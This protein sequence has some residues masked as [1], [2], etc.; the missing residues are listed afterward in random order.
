MSET[1]VIRLQSGTWTLRIKDVERLVFC[2][3]PV[4]FIVDASD[5]TITWPR[6]IRTEER[7]DSLA[8]ANDWGREVVTALAD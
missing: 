7:I 5:R 1:E 6:T 4:P 2:G 3:E 8:E